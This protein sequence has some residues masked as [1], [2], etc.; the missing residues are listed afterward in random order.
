[1]TTVA[2]RSR[3]NSPHQ[4]MASDAQRGGLPERRP[5]ARRQLVLERLE[6]RVVLTT[7]LTVTSLADSGTGTLRAAITAADAGSAADTYKIV[8]LHGL[9]GTISLESPCRT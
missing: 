7:V 1:M 5:L 9:S 6:E 2:K 8:F 4:T 3:I